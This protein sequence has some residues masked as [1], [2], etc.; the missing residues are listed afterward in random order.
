MLE[1]DSDIIDPAHADD[2]PGVAGAPTRSAPESAEWVV[3]ED[4]N[5]VK[6]GGKTYVR[7][8]A[9]RE[10]RSRAQHLSAQ[11]AKIEPLVPEFV[12][13]LN[14]KQHRGR[15]TMA[16]TAESTGDY[17]ADELN[18]L[19]ITRGYYQADNVTPDVARA[20]YELDLLTGVADRAAQKHVGP[21]AQATIQDRAQANYTAAL[22]KVYTDGQPI[23]DEKFIRAAFDALPPEYRAD[24]NIADIV[25]VIAAG[26]QNL[27]ERQSG[28]RR[29]GAREP[30]F[31]EGPAGRMS[32][33]SEALDAL[34]RAAARALGKT[35]EQYGKIQKAFGS[36]GRGGAILEDV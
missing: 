33:Q 30:N 32:N 18:G 16:R 11:L 29:G 22:N 35:D 5:Q 23:A 21:V 24:S 7:E 31:R 2:L 20:K 9:L 6:R 8:E 3:S 36:G 13:F 25:T 1:N 12:E 27:E 28:R 4:E 15:A 14:Q 10:E 26:L 17:T 34:D 19:A